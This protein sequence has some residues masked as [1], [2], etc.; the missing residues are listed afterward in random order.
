MRTTRLIFCS[1][2]LTLTFSP[3]RLGMARLLGGQLGFGAPD[4][5]AALPLLHRAAQLASADVPQP[6]YVRPLRAPTSR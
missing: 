6:A 5:G 1:L 3:Q 2:A 4:P